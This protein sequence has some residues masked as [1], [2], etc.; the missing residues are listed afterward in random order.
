M[1]YIQT[2]FWWCAMLGSSIAQKERPFMKQFEVNIQIREPA[3]IMIWTRANPLI[4][5]FGVE[6]FVG[7]AAAKEIL[8]MPEYDREL[9]DDTHDIVDGKFIIRDDSM[10]VKRGERIRY[11]FSVL[12]KETLSHSNF[13]QIIVTDNLFYRPKNNYCFS[14]CFTSNQNQA[15]EEIA[16]VKDI[17]EQKILQC[18]GPQASK[19]LFFPLANAATLVSDS[20]LYVKYR[21][22]QVD[23]LKPLINNVVTTYLAL[24]GVGFQMYTLIDKFKVLELGEL[25]LDV[26][27]FDTV[28]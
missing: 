14:Q 10:V 26:V 25:F 24:N 11:R 6:L 3:G 18:I 23:A 7:E 17:L 12:H 13:R 28:S 16:H 21:L 19:Y 5:K 1:R 20:E 4:H 27:D 8:S 9:Q 22:W 15:P 2:I